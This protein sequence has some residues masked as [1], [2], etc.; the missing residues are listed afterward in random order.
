MKVLECRV[1]SQDRGEAGVREMHEVATQQAGLEQDMMN[2]PSIKSGHV[3]A[4]VHHIVTLFNILEAVLDLNLK[5]RVR[6]LRFTQYGKQKTMH[7]ICERAVSGGGFEAD[8]R[9]VMAAHGNST[10]FTTRGRLP[11]PV[12]AVRHHLQKRGEDLHCVNENYTS[13]LCSTCFECLG[14]MFGED[15]RS[16]WAVRRCHNSECDHM[17]WDRGVSA[18]LDILFVFSYEI[19]YGEHPQSSPRHTNYAFVDQELA[20]VLPE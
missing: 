4:I 15:G 17:V 11:S 6:E 12:K 19:E 16:I 3:E 9:P 18:C 7:D 14:P 13:K 8:E 10:L 5:Y 1:Q 2:L 20:P